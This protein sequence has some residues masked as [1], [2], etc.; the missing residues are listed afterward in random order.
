MMGLLN[1][2]LLISVFFRIS[3]FESRILSGMLHHAF[4]HPWMLWFLAALP[5][6]IVLG[7]W[8][9]RGR[10]KAL[11][12]LGDPAAVEMQLASRRGWRRLS[13]LCLLLGFLGLGVGMAGPQWGR[14]WNQ[15]AAPGRDLVV[16]IDC[17]RSM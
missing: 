10:R 15:S 2:G 14:D 16:V 12:R 4:A 3:N 9:A 6:L 1:F 11:E 5:A 17:S 8:S 7:V 13:G